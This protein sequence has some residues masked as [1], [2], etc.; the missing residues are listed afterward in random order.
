M[1]HNSLDSY[2]SKYTLLKETKSATMNSFRKKSFLLKLF[3]KAELSKVFTINL[4][5]IAAKLHGKVNYL[6]KKKVFFFLLLVIICV[7][8]IIIDSQILT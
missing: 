4:F 1:F 5:S 2:L 7:P 8:P 3:V 6:I